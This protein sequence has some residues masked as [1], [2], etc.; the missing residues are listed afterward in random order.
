MLHTAIISIFTIAVGFT[1]GDEPDG[2]CGTI[3]TPAVIKETQ[4]MLADG[5]WER[6]RSMNMDQ[7]GDET[8]YVKMKIHIVRYSN[9]TGGIL[10]VHVATAISDLNDHVAS[11]GLIF[12][13]H[14]AI[15][16]FDS[17]QYANCTIGESYSLRLIDE[18]DGALNVWF[19]PNFELCGISS[20]PADSIQGI[21]MNNGCSPMFNDHTTF[22]H[23]VGHY[24][25]LWHTHT[26]TNGT[27]C[28]D[29]SNC[30]IAG[31]LI[32]DTPADPNLSGNVN[33]ICQYLGSAPDPCGS[34][35]PYSPQVENFMSYSPNW[36][37][38]LFTSQQFSIFRWSAENE[39]SD[40]LVPSS[41]GACCTADFT[42]CVQA[43]EYQCETIGVWQGLGSVC[44]DGCEQ[45]VLGAC[46]IGENCV[47]LLMV[48]CL[49][50]GAD[51]MGAGIP[52]DSSVCAM[53]S[54]EGDVNESG[55]VDV[56]DLLAVIDQWGAS[57]T[58]ADVNYDG[59]VN[60]TDLL[61]V[62]GSWGPCE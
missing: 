26:T 7:R 8:Q 47:Q 3:E 6:A 53:P 21:V 27:E 12:F 54:C 57:N 55:Y 18:V 30:A 10:P 22:T 50:G 60:V 41:T 2:W 11:T 35:M 28:V 46:C 31:D 16:Y 36:C 43:Y 61:I 49:N 48:N 33:S 56:G 15:N 19:V 20:F 25:H 45:N 37:R 5:T 29:G 39:R 44:E 9:G 1:L 14:G 40:H 13:Q 58:S 42:A 52:C 32:C 59:I 24:F 4:R 62:V 38:D 23:E 17:D 34:G 51:W